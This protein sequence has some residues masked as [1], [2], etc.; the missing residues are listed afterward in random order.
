[1]RGKK[2][3]LYKLQKYIFITV[4]NTYRYLRIRQ[5]D[6]SLFCSLALPPMD[7]QLHAYIYIDIMYGFIKLE[8]IVA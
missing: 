7:E 3:F 8:C 2:A 1:M 6:M 5:E 4:S